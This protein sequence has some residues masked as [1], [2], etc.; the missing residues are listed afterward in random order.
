MVSAI[1]IQ[2][3]ENSDRLD[4]YLSQ[5]LSDL[6]RARIQQLIQQGC[7]QVNDTVC[8]SKKINLKTGDRIILEIPAIQ[9]LALIAEDI[10]LDILY[11]DDEL[12]ILN[13]PAGLVVHPAPGHPDGTL[14]NALLAHCPNLPGI[15]GVQ[16]PG[17]VHR[18]DKDTTGAIVI[19]KTDRAYQHLQAQIQAKTARREYLGLIYGVP[20]METGS[21][22]LP[23]GR[24]SQDR[25]KMDIVSV[26]EGGRAAITH[27]QVKERFGNYTLMHFQLETGRTHQIRVHSAKIGH[28]I[29]GDPIYSSA[30]S[31]GVNLPGQALHAW[32]LQLQH[33]VSGDLVEVTAPLPRSLTTLLEV[34]RRRSGIY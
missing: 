30:H 15:G 1:N 7:V 13:K 11:E 28:P 33:P 14:V 27:W 29:V 9:P 34:L 20:K 12:I 2:V 24:N 17:I 22:N 6:S 25:K 32:K 21:I 10:A 31:V 8:T 23:I 18:L 16:R 26:E 3:P 5:E 19:A 4:R